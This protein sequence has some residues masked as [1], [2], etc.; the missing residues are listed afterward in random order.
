M[1]KVCGSSA[2]KA[3]E[4]KGRAHSKKEE[5]G[6]MIATCRHSLVLKALDMTRGEIYAYP[7]IL[8]VLLVSSYMGAIITEGFIC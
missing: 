2:F 5:T 7:Y 4:N 3:N 6:A 1:S 8:Q